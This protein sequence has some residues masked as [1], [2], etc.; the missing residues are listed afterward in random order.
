M[1]GTLNIRTFIFIFWY[2]FVASAS[3]NIGQ[4]EQQLIL[5]LDARQIR[6]ILIELHGMAERSFWRVNSK[7]RRMKVYSSCSFHLKIYQTSHLIT[8]R[9]R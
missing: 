9:K 3:V 4:L 7:V 2:S 6:Q 8:H 1:H 5:S